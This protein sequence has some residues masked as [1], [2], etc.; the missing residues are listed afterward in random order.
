MRLVKTR[1]QDKLDIV[2]PVVIVTDVDGVLG[3]YLWWNERWH[4]ASWDKSG[5]FLPPSRSEWNHL[6]GWDLD[7]EAEVLESIDL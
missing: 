3:G 2:H 5:K 4:S 7:L 1:K 6:Q